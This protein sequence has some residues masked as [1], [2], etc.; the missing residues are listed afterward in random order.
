VPHRFYDTLATYYDELF[1]P[2]SEIV[3]RLVTLFADSDPSGPPGGGT[4]PA[5]NG[6]QAGSDA[7]SEVHDE[8]AGPKRA[9]RA[10]GSALPSILDIA[11]GTGTYTDALV[12]R[13]LTCHGIDGDPAMIERARATKR[14]TYEV[15]KMEDLGTPPR[16]P[17]VPYAGAF[18]VG[19][20][21]P[22][23]PDHETL[24]SV[25]A[26]VH[27]V[28]QEGAPFLVQVVNFARFAG[29]AAVRELPPIE[30]S[31][32]TMKRRYRSIPEDPDHVS[33]EVSLHPSGATEPVT[34]ATKL[35]V[36][37]PQ[38]LADALRAAGFSVTAPAGGF[39]GEP[40]EREESFVLVLT[41][42]A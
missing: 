20:S 33:F 11:C 27:G 5:V 36:V 21:L 29:H 22:H 32:I 14:G 16:P 24:R 7:Q 13:G 1:P 18:C 42:T 10:A 8:P 3:E 30:R 2:E 19:N 38:G 34:A 12:R 39:T 17:G 9:S 35:L 6:Y 26:D 25:V 40:F 37:D 41:A 15:R 4:D 23:L 28:L 31:D